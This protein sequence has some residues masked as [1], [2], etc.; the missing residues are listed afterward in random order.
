MSNELEL[1]FNNVF[2]IVITAIFM[3]LI[4]D[5]FGRKTIIIWMSLVHIAASFLTSFSTTYLMFVGTRFFVG[6]SIHAVWSA[7]FV[8]MLEL[9]PASN[10]SFCG[11]F[12]NF[13]WNIGSLLM[14]LCAYFI[15]SWNNLQLTF[16]GKVDSIFE[17]F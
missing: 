4:S 14:T 8:L 10:R 13:T 17:G 12:M 15:R 5:R 6:G 16:A 7:Y 11:G 3:G 9:I 2:K 1:S